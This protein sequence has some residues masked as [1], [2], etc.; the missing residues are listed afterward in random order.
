MSMRRILN[1][2]ATG[3]I[4]WVASWVFPSVVHIDGFLTLVAAAIVLWL[5]DIVVAIGC[6]LLALLFAAMGI[7]GVALFA[8]IAILFSQT[9]AL[10][11]MSGNLSG[12]LVD[13]FWPKILLSLCIA[14]VTTN[15]SNRTS[16]KTSSR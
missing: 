13:G 12:F 14:I 9:I 16:S 1:L 4:L 3:L 2:V 5:L 7:G 8:V 15:L 6:A 10:F 11:L